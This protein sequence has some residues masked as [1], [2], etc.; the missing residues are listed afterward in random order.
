MS[1]SIIAICAILIAHWVGDFILQSDWHATNKSKDNRV[2]FAHVLMYIV[3]IY[4]VGIFLMP[5][6]A[7]LIWT[8][9]NFVAHFITDYITSRITSKLWQKNDR[10]NFF[11]VVGLDQTLHFIV[12]FASFAFLMA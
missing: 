3:P 12:L 2:L 10:H 8:A 4:C 1:V 6:T 5:I 11:V 7:A 9:V